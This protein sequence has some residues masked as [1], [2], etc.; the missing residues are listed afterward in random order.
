MSNEFTVALVA[1]SLDLILMRQTAIANNIGNANSIDYHPIKIEFEQQLAEAI[2]S[3]DLS[4]TTPSIKTLNGS[5]K[6]DQEMALS[7]ENATWYRA[8]VK[9]INQQFSLLHTAIKG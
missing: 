4:Q 7:I 1:R 2:Q 5:V 6:I 3:K 8:L 9:G